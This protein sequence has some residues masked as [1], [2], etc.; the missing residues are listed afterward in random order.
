MLVIQL[1]I[2]DCV[3]LKEDYY[4]PRQTMTVISHELTRRRVLGGYLDF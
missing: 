3:K 1:S 2:A 4:L